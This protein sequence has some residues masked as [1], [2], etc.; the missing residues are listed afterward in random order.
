ME[1]GDVSLD[2][3]LLESARG[4]GE[5]PAEEAEKLQGLREIGEEGPQVQ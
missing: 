1:R 4:H 3:D 2:E 5:A